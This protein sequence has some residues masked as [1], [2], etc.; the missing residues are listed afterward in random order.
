MPGAGEFPDISSRQLTAGSFERKDEENGEDQNGLHSFGWHENREKMQ[1]VEEVILQ[2]R[3][4]LQLLQEQVCL[5]H[6][7]QQEGK[8]GRKGQA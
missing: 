6:G 1:G 4:K 8:G 5:Q 7:R 3:G 2:Q